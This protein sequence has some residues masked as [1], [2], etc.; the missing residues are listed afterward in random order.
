M[1]YKIITIIFK[2]GTN[3][4]YGNKIENQYNINDNF[5]DIEGA[6]GEYN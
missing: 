1:K 2:I 6:L 4:I 5:T 3:I